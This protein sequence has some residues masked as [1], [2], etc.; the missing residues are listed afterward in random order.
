MNK[1]L[2]LSF[3][4]PLFLF[5]DTTSILLYYDYCNGLAGR[6]EGCPSFLAGCLDLDGRLEL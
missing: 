6:E 1:L 5:E 4:F 3:F 2:L